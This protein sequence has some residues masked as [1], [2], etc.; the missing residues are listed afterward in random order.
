MPLL[1]KKFNILTAL[2]LFVDRASG[3]LNTTL[4]ASALAGATTVTLT[5]GT[6]GANGD[7]I[8]IGT[9][10]TMELCRIASGG[11]TTSLTLAK[12][13]KYDHANAEAVVGQ[14]A[15]NL[16]VPE[17][18]GVR[19]N[20]NGESTDVF[21]AVSRLAFGVI[22]GY[23]NLGLAWRFPFLTVDALAMAY[24]IP[25][26]K[27]IGNGTLAVQ[28]GTAGPRLF[29]SDGVTFGAIQN[30][31]GVFTGLLNDGSHFKMDCYN[32][33]FDPTAVSVTVSRGAL[34]TVPARALCSGAAADFTN[35]AFVPGIVVNT[36]AGGKADMVQEI[37][38]VDLLT[39]SG[40]ATTTS[41]TT[42]ADAYVIAVAS[43]SGIVD[44]DIVSIGSG[45][46]REYHRVH[47][48]SGN[49]LNLR[50]QVLRAHASGVAVVK[51]TRTALNV[52]QGGFT[53]AATGSVETQRS[54]Y[55]RVSL[56]Y[57]AQNVA[58]TMACNLDAIK[59]ESFYTALG[60]P[61]SAYSNS[62]L[63]INNNIGKAS[64]AS[65]YITG[66]TNGQKV[67]NILGWNGAAQIGGEAQFTQAAT[68]QLPLLYKPNGFS[69][70][71]HA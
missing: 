41:G 70:W 24:G 34:T 58:V 54:E 57:R 56:G 28:S 64:E 29:T 4:A 31:N 20:F 10:E 39:A 44:G 55:A 26:A 53:L 32:L 25:R 71:M 8:R 17:A 43:A 66:L 49:N 67:F 68:A 16:G 15:L 6:N 23:V 5:A 52:A 47:T 36:Y 59:P 42:A 51:Q 18:D 22:N 46:L 48:V 27:V 40:T 60:I 37:T 21:S 2:Y 38:S 1:D 45:D 63:P 12:P 50:T 62:V 33:T 3:H 35:S 13:L 65:F 69:M 9:G 14:E 7:D 61:S 11:G 30:V 19:F